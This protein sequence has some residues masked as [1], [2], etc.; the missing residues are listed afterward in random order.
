M[1]GKDT[2]DLLK[3]VRSK[4]ATENNIPWESSECHH[5]GPCKGTCP[6]CEQEVRQLEKALENKRHLGQGIA[7][8]GIAS[9]IVLSATACTPLDGFF[10]VESTGDVAIIDETSTFDDIELEGDVTFSEDDTMEVQ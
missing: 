5:E 2:C 1:Q 9:S 10:N 6:K 7:L 4:I 8:A 3:E